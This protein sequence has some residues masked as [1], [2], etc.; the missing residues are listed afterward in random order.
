VRTPSE[1]V[2]VPTERVS[3][4]PATVRRAGKIHH[5]YCMELPF[6]PFD[7]GQDGR[8]V[9]VIWPLWNLFDFAPE[10]RARTDTPSS[11]TIRKRTRHTLSLAKA[12]KP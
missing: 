8:H 6:A 12:K 10:E 11:A 7:Q 2:D 3:E 5:C 9:D 4:N 1:A